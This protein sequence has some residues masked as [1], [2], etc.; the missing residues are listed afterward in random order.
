MKIS[1]DVNI[2]FLQQ[3]RTTAKAT[4]RVAASFPAFSQPTVS[5]RQAPLIRTLAQ[6]ER[7]L[8][9]EQED[10]QNFALI[11]EKNIASLSVRKASKVNNVEKKEIKSVSA[12]FEPASPKIKRITL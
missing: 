8:S 2:A 5:P 12:R 1:S 4:Q 3:S 7:N 6:S 11:R 9:K 10:K